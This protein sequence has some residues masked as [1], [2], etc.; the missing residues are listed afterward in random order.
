LV[1]HVAQFEKMIGITTL[2]Y[3]GFAIHIECNS[4]ADPP[5]RATIRRRFQE[6]RPRP[7]MF[8]GATE[9]DSLSVQGAVDRILAGEAAQENP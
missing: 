7:S 9:E 5:C 3:R 1:S 2:T 4:D 6:L 8:I